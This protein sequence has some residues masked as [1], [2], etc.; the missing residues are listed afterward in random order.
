MQK[1]TG[2]KERSLPIFGSFIER[3]SELNA[4]LLMMQEQSQDNSYHSVSQYCHVLNW[5]SQP[6]EALQRLSAA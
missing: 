6:D 1:F 5:A 2:D 3:R 4:Q